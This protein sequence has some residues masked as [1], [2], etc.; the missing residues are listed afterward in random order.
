MKMISNKKRDILIV[1]GLLFILEKKVF[2]NDDFIYAPCSFPFDAAHNNVVL[3]ERFRVEEHRYYNIRLDFYHQ[4]GEKAEALRKLLNDEEA[5]FLTDSIK[6][7]VP[8]RITYDYFMRKKTFSS[9]HEKNAELTEAFSKYNDAMHEA[10]KSNNSEN[11]KFLYLPQNKKGLIPL[12]VKVSSVKDNGQQE[13][14]FEKILDTLGMDAGG[15]GRFARNIY[16]AVLQPDVTYEI[17]AKTMRDSPLFFENPIQ[18]GITFNPKLST[19]D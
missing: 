18:L 1:F 13:V 16:G 12:Y 6:S 10:I 7:G 19:K 3:V 8:I 5:L 17:T 11:N 14:I 4:G 15:G 2:A 9:V